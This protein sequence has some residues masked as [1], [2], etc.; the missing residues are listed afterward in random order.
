M[1]CLFCG[2]SFKVNWCSIFTKSARDHLESFEISSEHLFTPPLCTPDTQQQQRYPDSTGAAVW[3]ARAWPAPVDSHSFLM[4]SATDKPALSSVKPDVKIAL[5]KE[6]AEFY[7]PFHFQDSVFSLEDVKRNDSQRSH[8]ILTFHHVLTAQECSYLRNLVEN[9][10]KLSFWNSLGR[11]DENARL[12]RDA[13]TIEVIHEELAALI[14][15]RIEHLIDFDP[16][17]IGEDEVDHPLYERELPGTWRPVGMN[18]NFLF[19][20]YPQGGHFAPHTDGREIHRKTA[21]HLSS[22][23]LT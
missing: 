14:W 19:A 6:T 15:S 11:E 10:E 8:G 17:E 2:C 16:I 12:F 1:W 23:D 7:H 3:L 21:S 9:E 13:D 5:R 20:I 22:P 4:T 18:Q